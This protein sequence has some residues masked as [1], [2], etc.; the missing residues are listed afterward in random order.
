M[1]FLE[2]IILSASL[3]LQYTAYAAV[4]AQ[5]QKFLDLSIQDCKMTILLNKLRK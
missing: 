5:V 3:L 2:K 1:L 4:G